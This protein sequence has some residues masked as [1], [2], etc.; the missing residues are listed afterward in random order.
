MRLATESSDK[1]EREDKE[2]GESSSIQRDALLSLY[3]V[4]G[5]E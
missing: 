2:G 5:W 1:E 3:F 4:K